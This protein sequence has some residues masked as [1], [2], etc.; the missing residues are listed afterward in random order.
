MHNFQAVGTEKTDKERAV[1]G[2]AGNFDFF[3]LQI[4]QSIVK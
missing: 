3:L 1:C 2:K 4:I